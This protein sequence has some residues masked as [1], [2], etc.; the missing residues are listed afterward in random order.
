MSGQYYSSRKNPSMIIC[1]YIFAQYSPNLF[2]I[3]M[4]VFLVGGKLVF[5]TC[6]HAETNCSNRRPSRAPS[7]HKNVTKCIPQGSGKSYEVIN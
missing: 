3:V 7:R 6:I 1:K 5:Y 4:F 2:K